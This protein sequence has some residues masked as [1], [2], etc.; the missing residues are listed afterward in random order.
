[1]NL[2]DG[3]SL[4]GEENFLRGRFGRTEKFVSLQKVVGFFEI[5]RLAV[6]RKEAKEKVRY[7]YIYIIKR[8]ELAYI[9]YI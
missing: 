6:K 5:L 3:F 8:A 9:I 7:I 4:E 1:M 2:D